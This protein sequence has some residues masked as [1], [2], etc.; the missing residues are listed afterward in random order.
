M[1][2]LSVALTQSFS[3]DAGVSGE[4]GDRIVSR[5]RE[6]KKLG[7][8][9]ATPHMVGWNRET[10]GISAKIEG[11][12]TRAHSAVRPDARFSRWRGR[13]L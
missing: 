11:V 9:A 1:K 2:V 4:E 12:E 3:L 13:E 5:P 7:R 10:A 6:V 8:P